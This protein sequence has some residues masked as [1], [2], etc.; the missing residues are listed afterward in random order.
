MLS[1]QSRQ[2]EFTGGLEA[3]RFLEWHAAGMKAVRAK[4]L[5]FAYDTPE[6]WEPLRCA[7][8]LC[9]QAGFS[10]QS[11]AIRSYVLC[12]WPKDTLDA[13]ENRLRAV[14][15]LG[16]IPMAMLWRDA[17]GKRNPAWRTFQRIWA[18]P[19]S[20]GGRLL[21]GVEHDEMPEVR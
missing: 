12:G 11:H 5:F 7:A 21:D 1:K 3:T 10:Q 9:W 13:A 4:Q 19:A 8:A 20:I 17:T 2:P 6:D 18:R 16:V 15:S 14:L